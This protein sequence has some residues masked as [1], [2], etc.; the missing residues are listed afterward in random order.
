LRKDPD[1]FIQRNRSQKG[2]YFAL[3]AFIKPGM[4]ARSLL[5]LILG[6]NGTPLYCPISFAS[7]S[8]HFP[9]QPTMADTEVGAS[10]L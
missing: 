9:Q 5:S 3:E 2:F 7:Y 8:L 6:W 1:F 10:R 4:A